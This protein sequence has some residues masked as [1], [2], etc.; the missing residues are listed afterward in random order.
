[1]KEYRQYPSFWVGISRELDLVTMVFNFASKW[2]VL[3]SVTGLV[4]A[5]SY[6]L[7]ISHILQNLHFP[8]S[9]EDWIRSLQL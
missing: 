3:Y 2:S 4:T 7:G 1:M 9:K 6:D 8:I 5:S